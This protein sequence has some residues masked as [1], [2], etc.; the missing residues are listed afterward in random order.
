MASVCQNAAHHFGD[1]KLYNLS[2]LI[3]MEHDRPKTAPLMLHLL[4]IVRILGGRLLLRL[5][6]VVFSLLQRR[7]L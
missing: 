7:F 2:E 5:I 6:R 3:G 4:R 1:R